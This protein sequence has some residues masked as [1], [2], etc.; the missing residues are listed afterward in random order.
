[1]VKNVWKH[2]LIVKYL[3]DL[4]VEQL[5]GIWK[6]PSEVEQFAPEKGP[7]PQF[8]KVQKSLARNHPFL[9]GAMF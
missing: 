2:H 3:L 5:L 1:M 6:N 9:Q 8:R 4:V 7:H